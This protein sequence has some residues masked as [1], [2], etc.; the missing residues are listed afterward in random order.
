VST[1]FF[2]WS[3]PTEV[4]TI[5]YMKVLLG[6]LPMMGI[7]CTM[8]SAGQIINPLVIQFFLTLTGNL[9]IERYDNI[10]SI[11]P[12]LFHFCLHRYRGAEGGTD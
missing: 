11:L 5:F 4:N 1:L 9:S 6:Q 2:N 8:Q 12:V 3:R 7:A 10:V